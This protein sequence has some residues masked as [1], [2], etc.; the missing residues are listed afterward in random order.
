VP[1][2]NLDGLDSLLS[3]VQMPAGVPVATVAVGNARNAGL[4]AVRILAATDPDLQRRMVDFQAELRDK[5]HEKGQVVRGEAARR[6]G[7]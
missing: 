5:A 7:F 3:I 2:K 1:L 4:L 6:L